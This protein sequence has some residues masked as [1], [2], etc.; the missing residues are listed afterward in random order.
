[1]MAKPKEHLLSAALRVWADIRTEL[2]EPVASTG[3]AGELASDSGVTSEELQ[4]VAKWLQHTV[5][6][7]S[8]SAAVADGPKDPA[9]KPVSEE[10]IKAFTAALGTLLSIRRGA[11]ATLRA[12]LRDVAGSLAKAVDALGAAVG[13][14]G[15][16]VCAGQVLDRVQHFQRVSPTNRSAG[17]R[18]LMASLKQ[19]RDAKKELADSL[20]ESKNGEDSDED[21]GLDDFDGADELEPEER[22]VMVAVAATIDRLDER[23]KK[24]YS[25]ISAAT[26]VLAAL[27]VE[28]LAVCASKAQKAIDGLMVHGLGGMDVK[29]CTASLEELRTA[30]RG[31]ALED[32]ATSDE[33]LE[34][35]E[36]VQQAL[37]KVPA[38]D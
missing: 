25:A 37:A 33:L 19:L 3:S 2:D 38:E 27:Q 34:S 26:S 14:Q 36:V 17:L 12:E 15:M 32:V 23:L 30:S 10:V 8:A 18:R 6:K 31:L 4:K 7:F 29:A 22:E 13:T 9:L 16:A 11:G 35:V 24:T 28:A 1:M 21:L 20:K 5:T